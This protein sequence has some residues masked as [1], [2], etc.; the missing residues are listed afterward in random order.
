MQSKM[1]AE[2]AQLKQKI[3]GYAVKNGIL[4]RVIESNINAHRVQLEEANWENAPDEFKNKIA[5]LKA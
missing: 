3:V 2:S 1:E 5:V 4:K